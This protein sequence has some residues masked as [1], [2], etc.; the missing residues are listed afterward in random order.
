IRLPIYRRT[1]IM[2]RI[3]LK[4]VLLVLGILASFLC[5]W[6]IVNVSWNDLAAHVVDV[7]KAT[8]PKL[9]VRPVGSWDVYQT[10]TE[11][12]RYVYV[13]SGEKPP[14]ELKLRLV[15]KNAPGPVGAKP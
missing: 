15:V 14:K 2:R 4:K 11:P 5:G 8:R 1:K 10:T 13:R 6:V 9:P 7:D 3:S 12:I